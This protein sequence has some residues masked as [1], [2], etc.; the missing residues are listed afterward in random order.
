MKNWKVHGS[1][2]GQFQDIRAFAL[3]KAT[4]NADQDS[5]DT[6]RDSNRNLRNACQKICRLNQRPQSFSKRFPIK[7]L[8][9]FLIFSVLVTCKPVKPFS[10]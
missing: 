3:R 5:L 1:E 6:N 8:C 4:R 7:I 9:S 2:S 10:I